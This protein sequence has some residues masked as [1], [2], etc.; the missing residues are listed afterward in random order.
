MNQDNL[1]VT[2]AFLIEHIRD[3]KVIGKRELKNLIV[4]AGKAGLASRLCGD[5]GEAAFT[6]LALGIGTT[7]PAAGDTALQS[8]ITDSGMAR[9]AATISRVTTTVTNDTAQLVKQWSVSGT[10][11]VTEIGAFNAASVGTMLGRQT[12]AALNVAAGDSIQMT[13]KFQIA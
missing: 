8:E 4:S 6:Y 3:G 7:A 9:A 2:G 5:G 13:Y 10:K 1:K 11:A 12:F